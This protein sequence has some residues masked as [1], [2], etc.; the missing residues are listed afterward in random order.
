MNSIEDFKE[1]I[2]ECGL[3]PPD[4]ILLDHWYRF[5]GVGKSATNRSGFARLFGDG[6]AGIFGDWSCDM[7]QIWK[8]TG[9]PRSRAELSQYIREI[10]ASNADFK[11]IRKKEQK[12]AA[13][14][15]Q[16][17]WERA[18]PA[19]DNHPYLIAKGI[20]A[21]GARIHRGALVLP[22]HEFDQ[23]LVNLQMIH[24]NGTKRFLK[25][26]KKKGCAIFV[27][28]SV[29]IASRTIICEGWAT[30]CTLVSQDSSSTVFAALD[31]GNLKWVA[32]QV[33]RSWP[34]EEIWIAADDDRMTSGNPGLTAA[35]DAAFAVGA[36]VAKPQW[37]DDA[38][39]TLTDFND[40]AN[41]NKD[42][43]S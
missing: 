42:N 28:G 19:P 39:H 10:E 27:D 43:R 37:P 1:A 31:A 25:N 4:I 8:A 5:P 22:I 36:D 41:W 29:P 20:T 24:P 21:N 11:A 23:K 33:R 3:T 2:R 14:R 40:L 35:I 12:Q 15:A 32:T 18:E 13:K 26:G 34:N 30:G 17:I 7:S 6:Q 16:K 9:K 38:P